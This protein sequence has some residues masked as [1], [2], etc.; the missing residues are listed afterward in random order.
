[1]SD[2]QCAHLR[3]FDEVHIEQDCQELTGTH[4]NG[5]FFGCV[6]DRLTGLTLKDCDLNRSQ[7]LTSKVRDALGFTLTLDCNSF[8]GVEYSPLL[9]DLFLCLATLTKG[10]DAK[11]EKL[12]DVVGRER[13]AALLR[14]LRATE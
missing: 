5:L 1:M 6:F 11:R 8:S 12:L 7:F 2:A 14:I 10:N 9:F 4:E 3:D 13:A